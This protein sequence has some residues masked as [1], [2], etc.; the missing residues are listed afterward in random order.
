MVTFSFVALIILL[1]ILI[2]LFDMRL[3]EYSFLEAIINILY[4][5]IAIGRYIALF[6]AALGLISSVII[7]M[8]IHRS[9][10]K[11]N[12]DERTQE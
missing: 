7:D 2:G 1:T 5:E 10:R 9:K 4:S 8:R 6:G 11:S 3:F 12:A